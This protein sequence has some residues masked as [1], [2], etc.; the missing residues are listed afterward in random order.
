MCIVVENSLESQLRVIYSTLIRSFLW[1]SRHRV[2]ALR[3]QGKLM[4]VGIYS[5]SGLNNLSLIRSRRDL[6]FR[7]WRSHCWTLLF[8]WEYK[9]FT[10]ARAAALIPNQNP[11]GLR[12][13]RTTKVVIHVYW[14]GF[15]TFMNV[16]FSSTIKCLREHR[17]VSIFWNTSTVGCHSKN[18]I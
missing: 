16:K 14:T 7:S 11:L 12:S 6:I 1:V 10:Q 9:S 5:L 2:I 13:K 18:A 15:G 8:D 17:H 4:T 3:S